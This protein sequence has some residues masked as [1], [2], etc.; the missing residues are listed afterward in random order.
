LVFACDPQLNL[1]SPK[2]TRQTIEG[3]E[4]AVAHLRQC[5]PS[6]EAYLSCTVL[7]NGTPDLSEKQSR[8]VLAADCGAIAKA[9]TGHTALCGVVL[10][11]QKCAASSP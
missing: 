6:Y 7:D 1:S 2:P 9:V 3:C 4:P 11:G 5:C 8:C 10:T